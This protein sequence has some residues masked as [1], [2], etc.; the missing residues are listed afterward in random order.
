MTKPR[1]TNPLSGLINL[2]K[3][4]GI[5]SAQALNRVRKIIGQR[6]SGHAGTLD[7]LAGGVL[8]LCLGKGTKLVESIMDHP[9]VYRAQ[10]R[11]DAT[12]ESLDSDSPLQPVAVAGIPSREDVVH[13]CRGFEGV[14]QQMPPKI[15]AVKIGGV[16]AYK[17]T[18]RREEVIL[19]PR[20]VHVYW[21]HLHDYAWPEIDI[22]VCSGRGTYIRSLISDLGLALGV[23]G[24]LTGLTRTRV[25]PFAAGD[26]VTLEQLETAGAPEAYVIDLECARDMLAPH[27]ITIPPRP[28][29]VP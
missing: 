14:I 21:I 2:D 13:R 20:P 18:R 7:P 11:L 17:R 22:E 26:A 3:P 25:G 16:P 9:K 15:S 8:V 29:N 5:S 10:A 27:S 4:T 23:G 12:S 1:N 19:K 6:K 24:C 28:D